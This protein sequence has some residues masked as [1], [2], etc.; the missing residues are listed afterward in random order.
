MWR[1]RLGD[2]FDRIKNSL[3]MPTGKQATSFPSAHIC[4]CNLRVV[5][6]A[7]DHIVGISDCESTGCKDIALTAADI[8][9]LQLNEK[10]LGRTIATVLGLEA[11]EVDLGIPRTKQIAVLGG[12]SMPIVL[13]LAQNQ[14]AF[15]DVVQRLVLRFEKHFILLAPSGRF[16]DGNLHGLLNH[17]KAGFFPL[18]MILTLMPSGLLHA[19]KSG[20]ELFSRYLPQTAEPVGQSE[21]MRVFELLRKLRTEAG[22]E[23]AP[24]FD[25]FNYLVL[26]GLSQRETARRCGCSPALMSTRVATLEKRFERRIEELRALASDIR[27]MGSTVKGDRYRRRSEGA[28]TEESERWD[29]EEETSDEVR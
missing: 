14:R 10:K 13:T 5:Q 11:R 21:A 22:T 3:L 27:E 20:G 28:R 2:D 19:A 16:L 24:L 1:R 29:S 7:P 4:E 18:D 8:A 9:L 25:V 26:D 12:V 6:H 15:T 17:A 23:V